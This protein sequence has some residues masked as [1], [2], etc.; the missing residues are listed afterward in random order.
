[1]IDQ[2]R[3][4][5]LFARLEDLLTHNGAA[6]KPQRVHHVRTTVRRLEAVIEVCYPEPT[7]R[8]TKLKRQLK[9]LRKR[10]GKVRDV[11]VQ[12]AALRGLKIGREG[13]RKARLMSHLADDRSDAEERFRKTVH[14]AVSKKL[15]KRLRQT[16]D[17]VAK[18]IAPPEP[19]QPVQTPTWIGFDPVSAALRMFAR[20]T[21]QT[22]TLTP[23]NLHLYRTRCK[24]IRYIAEMAGNTR[25]A[26]RINSALKRLQDAIGDWHDWATLT[27]SAEEL[28]ARS[29]DSAL[30]AAM[31]NVTSAKFV[32]ARTQAD[33]IRRELM[34]EY[35]DMLS[36]ER[37]KRH[38]RPSRSSRKPSAALKRKP[39][40]SV[41]KAL[42]AAEVA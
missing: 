3:T 9:K 15:P 35:R 28:F 18:S 7:S 38:A 14:S 40:A 5:S 41:P 17:E 25:E 13:E 10:A 27:Q 6:A 36:C 39:V 37:E 29:L 2:E 12:I 23:E 22:S 34:R 26:K 42:T 20:A 30:I 33:E 19:N 24:H 32:E 4:Q 31:R 16:A 1:M 8:I 11:D 21:R